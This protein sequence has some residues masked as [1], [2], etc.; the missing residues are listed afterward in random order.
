MP[1]VHAS[2]DRAVHGSPCRGHLSAVVAIAFAASLLG[3]PVASAVTIVGP[4]SSPGLAIDEAGTAY[5]AWNGPEETSALRFCR[6]PRGATECD[7]DAASTIA[8]AGGSLTRAFVTVSGTRV[9]VVSY[10]YPVTGSDDFS[11]TYRY[12]S[13]DSGTTF[14]AGVKVGS[15]PFFEAVEGPGD[16]LSGVTHGDAQGMGFQSV[17]LDGSPGPL[18]LFAQLSTTHPNVGSVGLVDAATPLVTFTNATSAA[19]FSV[20]NGSGSLNDVASWSAPVDIGSAVSPKLAG[21]PTGLFLQAG[22]VSGAIFV[23]KYNGTA[24]DPAVPV[25]T[26]E[27]LRQHLFQ[28]ASGRLY[29]VMQR[30]DA[31]GLHLIGASSDGGSAWRSGTL[32]T[33]NAG[34]EGAF[35]DPRVATAADHIGVAVWRASAA[36]DIRVTP[37][38]PDAPASQA[39]TAPKPK[40]RF[41]VAGS[42]TRAGKLVR[43]AITGKLQ[44]PTAVSVASGC[45]GRVKLS[46]QRGTSVIATKTV[47]MAGRCAFRAN[48]SVK[49]SSVK[50]ASR[51]LVRLD[52]NGNGALASKTKISSIAVKK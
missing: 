30:G 19:Q 2:S 49:A 41:A 42:A 16:T 51:L 4:G 33:Q 48:L 7:A 21:G 45:R 52:F 46:V 8:A 50:T 47:A 9:V 25:G 1:N 20:Y 12:T 39:P 44:R 27:P 6:L 15:V 5:I 38:G 11:G 35:S 31:S 13:T 24:F 40:P 37:V 23:R 29:S 36:G 17:P 22:T 28:D 26:G 10:R 3:A 43:I 34:V 32:V 18:D 14:G